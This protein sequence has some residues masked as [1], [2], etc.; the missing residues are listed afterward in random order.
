MDIDT[1]RQQA[2]RAIEEMRTER[3]AREAEWLASDTYALTQKIILNFQ[4]HSF[5][6]KAIR[7]SSQMNMQII[8]DIDRRFHKFSGLDGTIGTIYGIPVV[9]DDS[10]P[11]GEAVV[12]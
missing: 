3:E 7:I 8:L 6:Y 10:V 5:K 4:P 1:Y 9:I 12:E 2:A 11:Y